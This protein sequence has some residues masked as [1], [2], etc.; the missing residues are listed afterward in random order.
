MRKKLIQL[1]ICVLLLCLVTSC[2]KENK[3][4]HNDNFG[5]D[6]GFSDN[7]DN[8][9]NGSGDNDNNDGYTPSDPEKDFPDTDYGD[10]TCDHT[11]S[12]TWSSN[13]DEHWHKAT[14]EHST[15]KSDVATHAD[16]DEDGLCDV[17]EYEVG[18]THTFMLEWTYD[19]THHWHTSTC[20]H[21]SAKGELGAHIDSNSDGACDFCA[22][23]MHVVTPLGKCSV[24][25]DK[26]F[27][28]S[29]T[30]ISDVINIAV[31]SASKVTG[32]RVE[33]ENVCTEL[34]LDHE[35]PAPE[36][37]MRIISSQERE[38]LYTL[39]NGSAY[40]KTLHKATYDETVRTGTQENWYEGSDGNS[41]FGVY[42]IDYG[43]VMPDSASP[44]DLIGYSFVVS[45]LANARGPENL[46]YTLY[47]LSQ[48]TYASGYT[49][50]EADGLY[51]FSFN[52]L[53]LNTS[54]GEGV[55]A[56]YYKLEISFSVSDSGVLTRLDV[57]CD[58][59]TNS[60]HYEDE[61]EN[62][63][64]NDYTFNQST[65]EI[66]MKNNAIPDTYTFNIEQYE[67]VRI[68]V[69]EHPEAEFVPDNFDI[70][71][72]AELSEKASDTV[73]VTVG[74]STR[75]YLGNFTPVGASVSYLGD[76][77]KAFCDSTDVFCSVSTIS[78]S[79]MI[80]AK[81]EGTYT[82]RIFADNVVK[83]I[84]VV[85]KS[86]TPSWQEP[87]ENSVEIYITDNNAWVDFAEFTAM[88]DGDY[89]FTIAPG[90]YLGAMEKGRAP[91]ADYNR[92][93]ENGVPK[94]GSVTV[95][96]KKGET[97]KFYVMSQEKYINVYIPYVISAYSGA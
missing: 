57:K 59:Y 78:S 58:C 67:G 92:V 19:T 12:D 26:L 97:Y 63:L 1:L 83:D 62:D 89:T 50:S 77:F 84:T 76:K 53:K 2:D 14:C 22:I 38:I 32:G 68:Y 93:D 36:D 48:D 79:V 51:T 44:Q 87:I 96:L 28:V 33:Y 16:I 74:K 24:C 88:V 54:T 9:V 69:S 10:V 13:S 23:H 29:V 31:S 90:V 65:Y 37:T 25:G 45:T 35:T 27:D 11:Y 80:F 95:S 18:H 86:N 17:C 81:S 49:D 40:Y 52:Y 64:N 7:A 6:T 82:V 20:S 8:N 60:L 94:G 47:R 43:P 85:A 34:K 46:L 21:E 73:E 42:S 30:D 91:W 71:L 55:H 4:E 39:G 72:D 5:D 75:V 66:T 56:D 70:Y 3:E 41:V 61:I 15:L